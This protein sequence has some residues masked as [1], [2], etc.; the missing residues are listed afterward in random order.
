M[1]R[2]RQ[3]GDPHNPPDEL[4]QCETIAGR[5]QVMSLFRQLIPTS[6]DKCMSAISVQMKTETSNE[7]AG[8]CHV[9][10]HNIRGRCG[11]LRG[12]NFHRGSIGY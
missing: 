4:R 7:S 12:W 10:D 5:E 2:P 8:V 6:V 1:N 11:S 9:T 3:Y